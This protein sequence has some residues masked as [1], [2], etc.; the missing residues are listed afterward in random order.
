MAEREI[1][2]LADYPS[3]S[4]SSKEAAEPRKKVVKKEKKVERVTTTKAVRKKQGLGSRLRD[5]VGGDDVGSIG[6]YVLYDVLIPA[7]KSTLSD[8]VTG[9][10]EMLLYGERRQGGNRVSHQRGRSYV[11]YRSYYDD[12]RR[13][14]ERRVHRKSKRGFE[15]VILS[16]RREADEVLSQLVDIVSQF[17]YVTVGDLYEMIGEDQDYTDEKWGWDNLYAAYVE[18]VRE[19][20]LLHLPKPILLD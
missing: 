16:S 9:G 20:Y 5:A 13:A 14:P 10:I 4:F 6:E 11:S 7:A 19:G 12:D 18:R 3:N 17:E 1:V 15:D 2:K 8:I